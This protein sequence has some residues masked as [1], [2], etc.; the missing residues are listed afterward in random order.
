MCLTTVG[1]MTNSWR[2]KLEIDA[3]NRDTIRVRPHRFGSGT[4]AVA[5]VRTG[6]LLVYCLDAA[7]VQSMAAAWTEAHRSTHL[8][9]T[10][11]AQVTGGVRRPLPAGS[12]FPVAE[13]VAD[14]SQP[15]EVSPPSAGQAFVVVT[16][17]WLIV[18]VHDQAALQAYTNA[19]TEALALLDTPA[20]PTAFDELVRDAT[21]RGFIRRCRLPHS[22]L[23]CRRR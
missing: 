14:G 17:D 23:R 2:M 7:S 18:R 12:A 21:S 22:G 10:K 15:W 3:H 20:E 9:P 6:P 19:W 16:T 4:E 1:A 8:L 5:A 11:S 13:A